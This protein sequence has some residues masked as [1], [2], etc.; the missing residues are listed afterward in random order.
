M[1]PLDALPGLPPW[2]VMGGVL[3]GAAALLTVL[4]G[5]ILG[6]PKL[7]REIQSL[8]RQALE[9]ARAVRA[10]QHEVQPNS[11]GSMRDAT[12]RTEIA[13]TQLLT[14]ISAMRDDIADIKQAQRRQDVEIAQV[15]SGIGHLAERMSI[16]E[17][18]SDDR[19]HRHEQRLARLEDT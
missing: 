7:V 14:E 18:R 15:N 3:T 4:G 5:A 17:R 13:A 2:E 1:L 16:A 9:T 10:V 12:D 6:I 11:G 8:R 19:H